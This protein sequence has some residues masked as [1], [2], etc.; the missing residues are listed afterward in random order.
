MNN[1][2]VAVN[3]TNHTETSSEEDHDDIRSIA[4]PSKDSI[5]TIKVAANEME[6]LQSIAAKGGSNNSDTIVNNNLKSNNLKNKNINSN[7]NNQSKQFSN[8][9]AIP[10]TD[11]NANLPKPEINPPIDKVQIGEFFPSV[12]NRIIK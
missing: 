9:I 2:V 8:P 3:N 7:I 4:H 11:T 12:Y 1:V 6:R 10:V 5:P